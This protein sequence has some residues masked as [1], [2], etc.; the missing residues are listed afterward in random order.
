MRREDRG[1]APAARGNAPTGAV[2]QRPTAVR[3]GPGFLAIAL[4]SSL[5]AA[6]AGQ[7]GALFAESGSTPPLREPVKAGKPQAGKSKA[8]AAKAGPAR[9]GARPDTRATVRSEAKA[10]A[11]PPAGSAMTTASLGKAGADTIVDLPYRPEIGS[12][13]IGTSETRET[14]AKAGQVLESMTVRDRGEYRIDERLEKGYRVSYTLHDGSIDGNT[15]LTALMKPLI[16]S[17]KGQSYAYETDED[18]TPTRVVDVDRL[19]ALAIEAVDLM[20]RSKPEFSTVP[21]LKQF[22]D[23]IRAQYDSATPESGVDLFL[24]SV[25]RFS[26]VQ[27]VTNVPLGEERGYDDV[28]VNPLTG[29]KM[30]AKGSFKVA[31]VD[32]ANGLA[33]VEWRLAVLPEDLAKATRELVMRFLPEGTDSTKLEAV[34]AQMKM[35]HLDRATYKIALADGVVRRMDRTAIVK[36][37]GVETRTVVTMTLSPAR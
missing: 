15:P 21:Q 14:K 30:R 12:R 17:M 1:P 10:E 4:A 22:V 25:V 11:Q 33:T 8:A 26:M 3:L 24:E 5:L 6:C 34:M 23:G 9:A 13:W 35:E 37:Q 18:G 29:S 20:T 27:G 2:R 36:A 7:D 32:K 19:K 28:V 16:A 31:A